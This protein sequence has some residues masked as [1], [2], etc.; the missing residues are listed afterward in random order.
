MELDRR[1]KEY[2]DFGN[3]VNNLGRAIND[4]IQA[5]NFMKSDKLEK[6]EHEFRLAMANI[7]PK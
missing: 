5:R 6:L 3:N 4:H 2:N 1:L 7:K